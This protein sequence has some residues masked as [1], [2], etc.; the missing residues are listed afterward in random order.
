M[1]GDP[2]PVLLA[3]GI[4]IVLGLAFPWH[5]R[6]EVRWWLIDHSPFQCPRCKAWRLRR[7]TLAA[8]HRVA[9]YMRICHACHEELYP[10]E[11]RQ[12]R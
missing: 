12:R 10:D 6:M 4:G 3:F 11:H 7:D 2:L 5:T 9:G 1:T 8:E